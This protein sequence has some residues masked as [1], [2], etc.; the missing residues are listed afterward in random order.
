MTNENLETETPTNEAGEEQ[1]P[2]A[3]EESGELTKAQKAYESQ[4]IR[5]EK[6]E[7]ELKKLKAESEKAESTETPKNDQSN[8]PDYA[9]LAYLKAEGITHPDDQKAIQDEAA[10]LKLPLT[11]VL[12]ME[13]MQIK[14]KNAKD[15]REA[16]AGMPDGSGQSS[17]GPKNTVEHWIN[18]KN[19]DGTYQTPDDQEL[20][21]KVIDARLKQ[22]T[23]GKMFSEDLF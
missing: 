9:R 16:E 7:A 20:A 18:K 23:V 21:E 19:P 12:Q 4:K 15:Q 5:A 1:Q 3:V 11:D 14:L 6:A 8:E 13:H 17:G 22:E 2:Q 10:R